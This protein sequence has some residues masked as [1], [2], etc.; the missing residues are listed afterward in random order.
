[1]IDGPDDDTTAI[2]SRGNA[3]TYGEL[4]AQVAGLR[5]GLQG[6]GIGPGERVAIVCGNNW[7]F[8][9]SYLAILGIGAIA[10]PLNP[11]SPAVELTRE[12]DEIDAVAVIAGPASRR[13]LEGLDRGQLVSLTHLIVCDGELAEG[14][15]ALDDLVACEPIDVVD[16]DEDDLAVLIFTS[17]TAGFPKAAMLSHG[18]V[19]ANIAQLGGLEMEVQHGS[20]VALGV[21]PLFHIYGLTVVLGLTFTTGSSVVLVERFDPQSA[22]TTITS[23]KVTV[24][25][26]VPAMWNAWANLPGVPADAFAGIRI[27]TSGADRLPGEIAARL[28]ERF[29][30]VVHEGYGL[31]EA[32]PVVTSS[33]GEQLHLGSVGMPLPGVEVRLVDVDGADTLVG[34]SGEVWVRGP[35]V[36]KGYWHNPEATAQVLD[37][38]G[39]LHTGDL[40]VVDDDGYLSLVDRAK[41]LIIVSGF[42]VFPAEVEGELSAHPAVEACAVVGV[43]HPYSGEAVKAFVIVADGASTEEDELIAWCADRLARYKCPEKIMFVNELPIGLS[44]KVLRRSLA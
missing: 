2:I 3:T 23:H 12:L 20:D 36:F 13:S 33:I 24:L 17:G 1:M 43:P 35:N 7:Y 30:L 15:I 34:D 11:L 4:R 32:A 26:G 39:W 27:A 42:N 9:V 16:V 21:L 5:G 8:V 19:Q 22:L 40:A 37:A 28:H 38:D 14:E 44:G 29:G 18:N 10:V 6:L 41:D 31:T 25:P